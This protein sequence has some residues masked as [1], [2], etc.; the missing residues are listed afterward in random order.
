MRLITL[1][2]LLTAALG[3]ADINFSTSVVLK[4]PA[5]TQENEAQEIVAAINAWRQTQ[6]D[7]DGNLT[8]PT[9]RALAAAIL[10]DG[11]ERIVRQVCKR[12]SSLCPTG[13]KTVYQAI[14]A[15][16]ATKD[17]AVK[18]LVTIE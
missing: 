16:E 13:P 5:E 4:D 2:L 11:V 17:A 3:A 18:D 12:D 8:Y 10:Q 14:E 6:T 7:A 9:N 1:T 15:A